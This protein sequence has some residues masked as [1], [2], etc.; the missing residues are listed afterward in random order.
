MNIAFCYES[1]IPARG[2][3]ETYIADLSRRLA[4]DGHEV[5]LYASRWDAERLP[6]SMMFHQL[7]NITGPRFLRP[8]R[9]SNACLAAM[10]Q[11]QHDVTVGFDKT[12]GQD[13]LYPLGGLHVA[14]VDHNRRRF[15]S[16]VMR[17]VSRVVKS[18]DIA[19][20]SYRRLERR[21]YFGERRPLIIANS[22]FVREH[23]QHY[24]KASVNDVRV[25]HNAIDPGRF[26]QHDRLRLRQEARTR[27]GLSPSEV[28]GVFAARNYRLK[29]LGP[30]LAALERLV[31][32]PNHAKA[33]PPL[34][35]LICGNENPRGYFRW[36]QRHGL[37][38]FVQFIGT[39][40]D[41]REA[42]FAGDFLVHPTFY[43]PCSL[44]V[45]EAMA[46]D[47]PVI[48]TK[49]NGAAEL[50]TSHQEGI[51]IGNPHDADQFADALAVMLD[52]SRR[53]SFAQA[54]RKAAAAWTFDTHYDCMLRVFEEAARRKAAA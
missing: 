16:K 11:R 2:G 51:V 39:C 48:T 41:I 53:R 40:P 13:V 23:F 32:A 4:A 33:P 17:A 26:P 12:F 34:T 28:V 25:V 15:G 18:L 37:E 22:A 42:Y 9:F 19:H 7:P 44:V 1:V 31:K 50:M 20:W 29:G 46:C 52:S 24:Y 54:A 6:A 38:R 8:W 45:L 5:H 35:V 30:L 21:Q 3:C 10:A 36:V 47:L 49:Y 43:D 27:W 14:S